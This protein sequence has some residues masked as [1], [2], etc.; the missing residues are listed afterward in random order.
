[1]RQALVLD[2][3][4]PVV[5]SNRSLCH[6]RLKNHAEARFSDP[7]VPSCTS[8]IAQSDVSTVQQTPVH[9]LVSAEQI[10]LLMQVRRQV[11][12]VGV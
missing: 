3:S 8:G 2:P 9:T 5:H 4:D 1:M 10:Q 11:L 6:L 12:S 7:C